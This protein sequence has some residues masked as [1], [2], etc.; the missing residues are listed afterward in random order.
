LRSEILEALASEGQIS[1]DQIN[2]LPYLDQCFNGRN[3]GNY[4]YFIASKIIYYILMYLIYIF[5]IAPTDYSHWFLY[6]HLHQAHSDQ[7]G[8]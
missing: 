7:F 4:H 3:I 2:N 8:G 6:A 1:Y 5:R